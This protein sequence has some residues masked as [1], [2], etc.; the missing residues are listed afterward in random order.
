[1]VKAAGEDCNSSCTT[2]VTSVIAHAA[3]SSIP[4]EI[5]SAGAVI[6]TPVPNSSGAASTV[7]SIISS[8]SSSLVSGAAASE[9]GFTNPASGSASEI[10]RPT[11]SFLTGSALSSQQASIASVIEQSSYPYNYTFGPGGGIYPS[12]GTTL[13]STLPSSTATESETTTSTSSAEETTSTETASTAAAE[14]SATTSPEASS[15]GV[16]E[17]VQPKGAELALAVVAAVM[18]FL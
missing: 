16:A 10:P 2:T 3:L 7:G 12:N 9:S 8:V 1:M 14:S 4:S 11:I 17:V 5:D 13:T 18:L 6:I 15:G